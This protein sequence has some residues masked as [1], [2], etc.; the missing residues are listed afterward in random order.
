ML[1]PDAP[2]PKAFSL[3]DSEDLIGVSIVRAF[4]YGW[5]AHKRSVTTPHVD[6]ALADDDPCKITKLVLTALSGDRPV[7]VFV[8]ETRCVDCGVSIDVSSSGGKS[9]DREFCCPICGGEVLCL[10]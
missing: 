8:V 3:L 1:W 4:Q 7:S 9:T 5:A 2:E 6:K 10:Y